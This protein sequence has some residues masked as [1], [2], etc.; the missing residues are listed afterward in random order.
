MCINDLFYILLSMWHRDG[1]TECMHIF[2]HV[3]TYLCMCVC[4]YVYMHA[5]MAYYDT[6]IV[7]VWRD[8]ISPHKYLFVSII[9]SSD[10]KFWITKIRMR[11]LRSYSTPTPRSYSTPTP[12]SYSTPTPRS[13]NTPTPSNFSDV[14][15]TCLSFFNLMFK[16][17]CNETQT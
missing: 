15:L 1:C 6:V 13:Y 5:C 2:I 8:W 3:C 12:R 14:R 4:I 17:L 10:F 16:M 7:F 9:P 11:G